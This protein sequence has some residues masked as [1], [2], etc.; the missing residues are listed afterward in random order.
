MCRILTYEGKNQLF[1]Y[2]AIV[3]THW[4]A[5]AK[6]AAWLGRLRYDGLVSTVSTRAERRAD[7]RCV[8]VLVWSRKPIRNSVIRLRPPA[9]SIHQ[10][11][12]AKMLLRIS[13]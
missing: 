3:A 10:S 4:G 11:L 5:T 6:G 1:L 7:D 2:V 9:S 13:F 12:S 8:T